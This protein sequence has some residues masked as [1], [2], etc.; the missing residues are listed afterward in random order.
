MGKGHRVK[1]TRGTETDRLYHFPLLASNKPVALWASS[2][3]RFDGS[4]Q[5]HATLDPRTNVLIDLDCHSNRSVVKYLLQ[6]RT[7]EP[8]ITPNQ[9]EYAEELE[10]WLFRACQKLIHPRGIHFT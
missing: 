8:W 4:H 7:F 10:N 9:K 6:V 5:E 3:I 1:H 2:E